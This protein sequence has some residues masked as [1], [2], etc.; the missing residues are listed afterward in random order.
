MKKLTIYALAL[1]LLLSA[2][3]IR[4]NAVPEPEKTE[5]EIVAEPEPIRFYACGGDGPRR[6]SRAGNASGDFRL[7]CPEKEA[8][9]E[10]KSFMICSEKRGDPLFH[11]NSRRKNDKL[12]TKPAFYVK[13]M[14]CSPQGGKRGP[15][16]KGDK[17]GRGEYGSV[18]H[19]GRKSAGW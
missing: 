13:I 8:Q 9:K 14:L 11:T 1:A 16:I 6:V 12:F 2:C 7:V 4:E 10:V 18:C 17:K 15:Q 3:A 19:Q 5:P